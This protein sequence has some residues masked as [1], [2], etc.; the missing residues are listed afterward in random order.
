MG[1]RIKNVNNCDIDHDRYVVARLVDGELWFW[2]SWSDKD[3]AQ[4]VAWS[5]D[6]GVVVDMEEQE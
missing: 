5:F 6:N 3:A 1:M 4:R 2:G